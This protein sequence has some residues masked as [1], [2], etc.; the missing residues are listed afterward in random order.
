MFTELEFA[1]TH[2]SINRPIVVPGDAS[3]ALR[4]AHEIHR[5]IKGYAVF[6][7]RM[8]KM[9]K[10][11]PTGSRPQDISDTQGIV[12]LCLTPW[13]RVSRAFVTHPQDELHEN[14][15]AFLVLFASDVGLPIG[16]E[17]ESAVSVAITFDGSGVPHLIA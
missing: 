15:L 4:N 9:A 11:D 5:L 1:E 3:L 14:T 13:L 16:S 17:T 12:N 6:L 8:S 7:D 2:S 10:M